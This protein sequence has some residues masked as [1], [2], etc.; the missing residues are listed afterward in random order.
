MKA[1]KKRFK[2]QER[3][4]DDLMKERRRDRKELKRNLGMQ[5]ELLGMEKE[6]IDTMGLGELQGFVQGTRLKQ[7]FDYQALQLQELQKKL[8]KRLML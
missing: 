8:K 4:Y 2:A 6:D 1:E 5:A 3:R 7:S